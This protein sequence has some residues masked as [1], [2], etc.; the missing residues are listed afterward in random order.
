MAEEEGKR[1]PLVVAAERVARSNALLSGWM[2]KKK[3]AATPGGAAKWQKRYFMLLPGTNGVSYFVYYKTANVD[4]PILAAMDLSRAGVPALVSPAEE[5]SGSDAVF[6]IT[7]DRY[8]EFQASSKVEAQA[9]VDA[10]A[11]AQAAARKAGIPAPAL[12]AATPFSPTTTLDKGGQ[13]G[14]GGR[15][16]AVR[17]PGEVSRIKGSGNGKGQGSSS[18]S[19][20]CC[21]IS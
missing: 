16:G 1:N 12:A 3:L 20:L 6:A 11:R 7:W 15:G 2:K 13:G 21:Q 4:A 18:E 17:G 5:E 19:G 9:W 8:R 14:G 10:I